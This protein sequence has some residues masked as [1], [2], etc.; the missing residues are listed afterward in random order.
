M[1]ELGHCNFFLFLENPKGVVEE[2]TEGTIPLG[3]KSLTSSFT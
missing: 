2:E 1:V 3:S